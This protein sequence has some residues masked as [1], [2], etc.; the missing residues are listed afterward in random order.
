MVDIWVRSRVQRSDEGAFDA[1]VFDLGGVLVEVDFARAID[2]WAASA[3]VDPQRLRNRFSLDEHYESHERGEISIET[4]L[5]CVAKALG[6]DLTHSSLLAGWNSVLG[7]EMPGIA[8][9]VVSLS[10]ARPLFLFSNTN[11][12]HQRVWES[13][14]AALLGRFEQIF[15]STGLGLRKPE[16]GAYREVARR[17]G[18]AAERIL[19]LDDTPDNVHGARR[20]GLRAERVTSTEEV[21]EALS[22]HGLVPG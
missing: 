6:I 1:I 20:A 7:G 15:T 16:V 10:R 4:Y 11:L 17:M 9:L 21:R 3:S 18:V 14:H 8:E 22:A 5:G 19:F 2:S 12:A 13:A